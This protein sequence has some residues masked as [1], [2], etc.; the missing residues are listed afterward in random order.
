LS[1]DNLIYP[2]LI[3]D[4]KNR[5]QKVDSMPGVERYTIDKLLKRA[6]YCARLGIPAL[7]LFPAVEA[8]LK[9]ADGREATV[10]QQTAELVGV[11]VTTID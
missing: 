9:T 2:V 8:H 11:Y 1:V 3:I 4:G 7:A 5:T 6:E 10:D